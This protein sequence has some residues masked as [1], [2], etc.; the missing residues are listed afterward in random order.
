MADMDNT[1]QITNTFA[2]HMR[3]AVKQQFNVPLLW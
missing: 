3:K 2:V 1:D